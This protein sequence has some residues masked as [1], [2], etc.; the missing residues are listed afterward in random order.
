MSDKNLIQVQAAKQTAFATPVTPMTVKLMEITDI[1][2]TPILDVKRLA[3]MRGSMAP[4]YI[5]VLE[6]QG[7]TVQI[8]GTATYEDICYW[9]ESIFGVATPSGT[10]PYT[11]T[12]NAPLT[13]VVTSP[14]MFTL[15]VG[16]AVDGPYQVDGC[17]ATKLAF[18][19]KNAAELSYTV[20]LIG[21]K[22]DGAGTLAALSDRTV[23]PIMASDITPSVD[24][25]AGTI[26]ATALNATIYSMDWTIDT[27]RDVRYY[28]GSITP[29]RY[30]EPNTW[31]VTLKTVME[32]MAAS[33]NTAAFLTALIGLTPG[34]VFNK[35]VRMKAVNGTQNLQLDMAGVNEK[36]PVMWTYDNNIQTLDLT[37]MGMYN[38][39]LA[40]YLAYSSANSVA[41]LP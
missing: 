30:R 15:T 25:W 26:G 14:R 21:L 3:D 33:P 40:N 6:K 12:A 13:A 4:T 10:G 16:E 22:V 2:T 17:L 36:A 11:R 29:G 27:K 35:Q 18:S 7:V 39:T 23:T 34:S 37:L 31:D 32:F 28:L 38:P 20:D 9:L 8:K 24:A 5:A 41:T 1:T 19:V